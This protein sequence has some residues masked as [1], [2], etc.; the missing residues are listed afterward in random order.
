MDPDRVAAVGTSWSLVTE[1]ARPLFE[2]PAG[3]ALRVSFVHDQPWSGYNWYDG[4]YRSR[5]DFN[6]DLPIRLPRSSESSPTRPIPG[7]HLEHATKEE[8]L[9]D[10]VG[11]L[12]SSILLINAPECL[13]RRG[14]RTSVVGIVARPDGDARAADGD[15]DDRGAAD[16]RRSRAL[17]AAVERQAAIADATGDLGESR[18][19]AALMLHVD[20]ESRE[21][22]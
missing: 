10:E 3:E 19:N 8:V 13:V 6:L 14:W 7:H 4:G 16:G 15:G 20:G 2:V 1:R 22:P 12:E 18:V 21:G 11:Y 9:V 5:V 17:R